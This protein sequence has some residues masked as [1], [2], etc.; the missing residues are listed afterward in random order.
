MPTVGH[1]DGLWG[2]FLDRLAILGRAISSNDRDA[3]MAHKPGLERLG[4]AIRQQIYDS[5]PDQIHDDRAV[6]GAFT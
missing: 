2:R 3:A 6:G 5:V 4:S 1:L